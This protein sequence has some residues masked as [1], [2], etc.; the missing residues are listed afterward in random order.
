MSLDP[1][2]SRPLSLYNLISLSLFF[3]SRAQLSTIT[4]YYI[5]SEGVSR[6]LIRNWD[7]P[8]QKKMLP[9]S[10]VNLCWKCASNTEILFSE[11]LFIN[12]SFFFCILRIIHL[13]VQGRKQVFST[14]YNSKKMPRQ[15]LEYLYP[16]NCL[17]RSIFLNLKAF[18]LII[19]E[20]NGP[21]LKKSSYVSFMG[22]LLSLFSNV[23]I[24][25]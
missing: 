20:N 11:V 17:Q 3:I 25:L 13:P 21:F 10:I 2:L 5:L 18:H 14:K 12:I 9:C 24:Y 7:M 22:Q 16:C 1:F 15:I 8:N 19:R 6:V 4:F 23:C